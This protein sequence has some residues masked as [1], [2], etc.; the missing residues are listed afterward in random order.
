MDLFAWG[1]STVRLSST[2]RRALPC[3]M[4]LG[5]ATKNFDDPHTHGSMG[6][7]DLSGRATTS[8]QSEE[9]RALLF[10]QRKGDPVKK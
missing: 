4:Q 3:Q 5:H 7:G 6:S 10:V 2:M 9:F 1:G 8:V